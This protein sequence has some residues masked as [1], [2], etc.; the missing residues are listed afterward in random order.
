MS[1]A[2]LATSHI[3]SFE[4][5]L[6][7]LQAFTSSLD[8]KFILVEGLDH[9]FSVEILTRSSKDLKCSHVYLP[10]GIIIANKGYR[11]RLRL[12][13]DNRRRKNNI[14]NYKVNMFV[15]MGKE[16][17][18]QSTT[19]QGSS[20]FKRNRNELFHSQYLILKMYQ[21]I[22]KKIDTRCWLNKQR[23]GRQMPL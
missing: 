19:E 12:S 13:H 1:Y 6:F 20:P 14:S 3:Y 17:K 21:A 16:G 4:L 2:S 7:Q 10:I 8:H 15:A 9:P 11:Q 23:S 22:E 5:F 18:K